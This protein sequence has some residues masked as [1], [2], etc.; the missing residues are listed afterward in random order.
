[1]KR[2]I[3]TILF[4]S[5]VLPILVPYLSA[6]A[7]QALHLQ[8]D[9]RQTTTSHHHFQIEHYGLAASKVHTPHFDF[10]TYFESLHI[11]LITTDQQKLRVPFTD[12]QDIHY[13]VFADNILPASLPRMTQQ[14]QGPPKYA[15]QASFPGT[16]I[17]LAT[18]RLRI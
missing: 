4:L 5:F 17:Y 14:S 11:S 18:Q 1:M 3:A 6:H 7:V 16:S 15:W 10:L 2:F 13:V 8:Q 9:T 12:I